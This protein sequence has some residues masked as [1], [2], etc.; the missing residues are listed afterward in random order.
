[1]SRL[2]LV[3][4]AETEHN[5]RKV[6]QGQASAPNVI[7]AAG[8][9]QARACGLALAALGLPGP[10]VYASTYRRAGQT[11]GAIADALGTGVTVLEG[12]Q[13]MDVGSWAGRPYSAL[14]VSADRIRH[15]DGS[16]G[17]VGGESERQVRARLRVA[18]Q[19]ALARGGTPIVVSHGLALQAALCELLDVPFD[20]AWADQRYA[21]A[22]TA[23][24]EL[25]GGAGG[26]R[27]VRVADAGHLGSGR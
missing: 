19:G 4:H 22:N 27:V 24:T 16:F 1:M 18:L 10:R 7:S 2:F 6:L 9:R 8:E 12:L 26:W 13:E 20:D 14:E 21:H 11:A 17:F 25:E 15:E 3:R 5:R 23:V